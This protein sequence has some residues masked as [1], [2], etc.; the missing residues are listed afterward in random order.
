MRQ[1]FLRRFLANLVSKKEKKGV[2]K[3][4]KGIEESKNF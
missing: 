3:Q 1:K 2:K 4:G